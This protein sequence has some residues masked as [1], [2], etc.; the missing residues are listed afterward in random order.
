MARASCLLR[1]SLQVGRLRYIGFSEPTR[2]RAVV[3]VCDV[4]NHGLWPGQFTSASWTRA[5]AHLAVAAFCV[6]LFTA[7]RLT[8]YMG[9]WLYQRL[10]YEHLVLAAHV[11]GGAG[12]VAALTLGAHEVAMRSRVIPVW[13]VVANHGWSVGACLVVL[14]WWMCWPGLRPE[15]NEGRA[16]GA[17]VFLAAMLA[18]LRPFEAWVAGRARAKA[19][20]VW[21]PVVLWQA[22][23][24]HWE[25]ALN[26][27]K[28]DV[29]AQRGAVQWEQI[30]A[31]FAAT[32]LGL[33][34]TRWAARQ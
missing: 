12:L 7:Q 19:W 2:T 27:L 15:T 24:L 33:A 6:V 16:L 21:P 17:A 30:A 23:S 11:V 4:R 5:D 25:L 22:Y 18:G 3:C 32:L 29:T 20:R 34:W 28:D 8:G 1:R 14:L 26:F 31:D 9:L 13:R 10:A